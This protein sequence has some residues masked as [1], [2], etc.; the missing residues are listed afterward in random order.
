MG[1]VLSPDQLSSLLG[2]QKDRQQTGPSLEEIVA[3]T[4]DDLLALTEAAIG[5]VDGVLPLT[6]DQRQ[7]LHA[8]LKKRLMGALTDRPDR[9][10]E[11]A[12]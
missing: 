4:A 12:L 8:A 6:D 11:Q 5:D 3:P 2:G 1:K 7:A 10:P 9:S